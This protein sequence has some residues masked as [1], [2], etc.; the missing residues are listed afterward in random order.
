MMPWGERFTTPLAYPGHLSIL[1][2]GT[3]FDEGTMKNARQGN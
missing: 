1:A 3:F 2:V